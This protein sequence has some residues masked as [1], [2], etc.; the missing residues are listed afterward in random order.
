MFKTASECVEMYIQAVFDAGDQKTAG[1]ERRLLN[2]AVRA[3]G[4]TD[5][6]PMHAAMERIMKAHGGRLQPGLIGR[7]GGSALGTA[8]EHGAEQAGHRLD[9]VINAGRTAKYVKPYS[10]IAQ[11]SDVLRD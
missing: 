3:V 8:S 2:E 10:G 7:M 6:A 5:G 1:A 11:L 9:R 4:K